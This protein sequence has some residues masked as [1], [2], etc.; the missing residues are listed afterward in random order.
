MS[1]TSSDNPA[2]RYAVRADTAIG[3]LL[4]VGDSDA[5][6]RITWIAP[7][8]PAPPAHRANPL[9]A[10]AAR[11]LSSYARGDLRVFDLPVKAH[12]SPHEH[13]VWDQIKLIP[14]GETRTYGELATAISSSPRAVG[15]ACGANPVPV[16]VPCHR[17]MGQSGKLTGFSGGDGVATKS[18]LL[19]LERR[20]NAGQLG[21]LPLFSTS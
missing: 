9:L 6:T 1:T 13:A 16:L 3:A 2:G 4:I 18:L 7:E 10:E 21:H 20:H 12:G 8:T 15:R 14:Y 11:Q 19:N 5:V 17:V